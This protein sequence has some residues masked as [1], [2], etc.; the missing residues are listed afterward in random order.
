MHKKIKIL[1]LLIVLLFLNNKTKALTYGGCEYSTISNLKALINNINLSYTY[2]IK[3][4]NAYFNITLNNIPDNVYF[5]DSY[6]N[7]KYTHNDVKNGE[8]T[9]NSYKNIQSGRFVFY[10]DNGLCDD[11]KLG[12]KYYKFPIYNTRYKSEK[13]NSLQEYY[14]CK[15]WISKY[16]TD[17]EFEKK[18]SEYLAEKI[19]D[20]GQQKII[21]E[22]NLITKIVEFYVKYYYYLL[23]VIIVIFTLIMYISNKKSNFK[24]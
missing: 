12:S 16:Y 10:T 4:N 7:R 11:I 20:K 22:K 13:C 19:E 18:I 3:D 21:Y 5:Y 14:L 23:P 9:I 1:F 15:K 6:D 24:L 2:E 8:I 17:E